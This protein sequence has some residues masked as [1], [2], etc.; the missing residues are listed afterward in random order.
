M[1]GYRAGTSYRGISLRTS[2]R[3]F[4]GRSGTAD[5]KVY[6]VSAETAAVS[7]LYGRLTDPRRMECPITIKIPDRFEVNDNMIII[8][9]CP[10]ETELIMGPNIK[11]LP[12][13]EPM[14]DQIM[15]EVLIKVGDNITTDHILPAGAKILPLRS[16]IPAISEYTFEI[17]DSTFPKRSKETGGG[18]IVGGENYGQGSSREHAAL[19]PKYLGI[20]AVIAKSYARIHR[21]NLINFGIIPLVFADKDEYR[22]IEQGDNL[23]I[24]NIL[25]LF[26]EDELVVENIT[27]VEK[28]HVKHNLSGRQM[29]ILF[30]GGLLQYVKNK[31]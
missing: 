31:L 11:P 22:N 3:N 14:K 23:E 9:E 25:S 6:L 17:I 5:A 8:P 29:D 10:R 21:Q 1:R 13:F 19:A 7:A 28:Y 26:R 12:E 24:N 16:N 2:N 30:E 20:K 27:K 18:I 15:G 4:E